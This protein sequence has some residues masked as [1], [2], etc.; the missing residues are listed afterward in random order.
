VNWAGRV[1]AGDFNEV[2]TEPLQLRIP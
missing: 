2:V 1:G